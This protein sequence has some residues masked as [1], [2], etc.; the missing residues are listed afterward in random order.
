MKLSPVS[1][2]KYSTFARHECLLRFMIYFVIFSVTFKKSINIK[3]TNA[4]LCI[5]CCYFYKIQKNKN[6]NTV[7]GISK[8]GK[9]N[10]AGGILS[11]NSFIELCKGYLLLLADRSFDYNFPNNYFYNL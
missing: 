4:K 9:W 3:R 1:P 8:E 10:I 7:I 11:L 2:T 6:N 5:V